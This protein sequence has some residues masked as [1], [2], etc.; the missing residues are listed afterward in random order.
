MNLKSINLSRGSSYQLVKLSIFLFFETG[1]SFL[2]TCKNDHKTQ[3]VIKFYFFQDKKFKK[4]IPK[5]LF[6][7]KKGISK[8]EK[9][10]RGMRNLRD[11][12]DMILGN[13]I[14]FF[15]ENG[16]IRLDFGL[17]F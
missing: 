3:R 4:P 12:V 16:W 8:G 1:L 11:C 10:S 15:C 9:G 2:S 14:A 13:V 5:F 6:K 17:I 7:G